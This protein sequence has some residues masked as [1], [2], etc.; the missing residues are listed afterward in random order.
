MSTSSNTLVLTIATKEILPLCSEYL[1][2]QRQYASVNQFDH[3]LIEEKFWPHLHPSFSKVAYIK[4]ALEEYEF[5]IW[6]DADVAFMD[7]HK[8][9]TDLLRPDDSGYFLAAYHQKNWPQWIYL[10]AG[11]MVWRKTPAADKF[12][13]NWFFRCSEGYIE[14]KPWEQWYFDELIRESNYSGI[15]ACSA[16]EI[17]CFCPEIWHDGCRWQPGMPT[18]HMAGD[19]TWERRRQIYRDVYM[20]Q[21]I[22]K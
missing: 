16:H 13:K 7:Q 8:K 10:C 14:Y 19:A 22:K 5:V 11:L 12:I 21:V 9:L 2:N 17:G 20:K 18:V 6:A 3:R 1:D 4:A 15:R